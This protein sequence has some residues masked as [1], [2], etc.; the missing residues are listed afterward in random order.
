MADGVFKD[1]LGNKMTASHNLQIIFVEKRIDYLKK[2][3]E[4]IS[5][6]AHLDGYRQE[7]LLFVDNVL[8]ELGEISSSFH[9]SVYS[10]V[11]EAV[12]RCRRV[13][14]E[15]QSYLQLILF[16]N[17]SRALWRIRYLNL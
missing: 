5:L 16:L 1:D 9:S 10:D 13:R 4:D 12:W 2:A 14:A 15:S 3:L 8:K 7:H 6:Y 17:I 11:Q